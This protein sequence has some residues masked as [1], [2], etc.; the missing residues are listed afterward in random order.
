MGSDKTLHYRAIMSG[1]C[2]IGCYQDT[3]WYF[4]PAKTFTWILLPIMN[5]I[6][7]FIYGFFC[8]TF[9]D[10]WRRP[11]SSK[12]GTI[13]REHRNG[14]CK[15]CE[16]HRNNM[17]EKSNSICVFC[18][19]KPGD[20]KERILLGD[21]KASDDERELLEEIDTHKSNVTAISKLVTAATEN[22]FMPLLQLTLVFPNFIALFPQQDQAMIPSSEETGKGLLG[23]VEN[24]NSNWKFIVI[25]GSIT[26]S[27]FSL[28]KSLTLTY[29]SK[30]G[31]KSFQT[32]SRLAVLSIGIVLQVIPKIFAYQLFA[33][34]FIA[35]K[36]GANYIVPF[37]LIAPLIHSMVFAT[38]LFIARSINRNEKKCKG[39]KIILIKYH[40]TSTN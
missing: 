30:P 8:K 35:P 2:C 38:T 29:F 5:Q 23:Y 22:S 4:S 19:T 16:E 17:E 3:E 14:K 15:R 25:T 34:G 27:L 31:K 36:L 28:A 21:G 11:A 26:T 20:N 32:Y 7:A 39:E 18:D 24:L 37:L 13:D 12:I 33:F 10:Y 6:I 40:S 9:V 1:Y